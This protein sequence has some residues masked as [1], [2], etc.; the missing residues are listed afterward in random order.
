MT[1]TLQRYPKTAIR[2]SMIENDSCQRM[3]ASH[4][5]RETQKCGR[6]AG[7]VGCR[8]IQLGAARLKLPSITIDWWWACELRLQARINSCCASD[9][10][11]AKLPALG[12]L[13]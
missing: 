11:L 6:L 2:R 4:V 8:A 12:N 9:A 10:A 1:A 13:L 5:G 7:P 3:I